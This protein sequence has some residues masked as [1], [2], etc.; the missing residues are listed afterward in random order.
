MAARTEMETVRSK[1]RH[2]A[3]PSLA[4]QTAEHSAAPSMVL[5]SVTHSV[6]RTSA[7]RRAVPSGPQSMG[8]STAVLRVKLRDWPKERH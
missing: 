6:L 5:L 3:T 4:M 2:W 1:E 7:R 8:L